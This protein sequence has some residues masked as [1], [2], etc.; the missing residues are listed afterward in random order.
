MLLWISVIVTIIG[1]VVFFKTDLSETLGTIIVTTA[2]CSGLLAFVCFVF[3]IG[4]HSSYFRK[5]AMAEYEEKRNAILYVIEK[6]EGSVVGLASDISDY[7]S[8]VLHGRMRMHNIWFKNLS[9]DFYEDLEL[10]DVSTEE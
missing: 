8:S 5:T 9:Y 7:N 2:M 4:A 3:F 10:I 1:F 6:S